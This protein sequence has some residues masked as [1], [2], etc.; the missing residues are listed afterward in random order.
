MQTVQFMPF[1]LL[2]TDISN[3]YVYFIY[4]NLPNFKLNRCVENLNTKIFIDFF[5]LV[6]NIVYFILFIVYNNF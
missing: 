5:F 4:F 3:K 2:D 1:G 6:K